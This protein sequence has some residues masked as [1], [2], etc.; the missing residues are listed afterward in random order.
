MPVPHIARPDPSEYVPYFGRYVE[1]VPD[2]DILALLERQIGETAALLAGLTEEQANA[3]Y[4]VG[5]WSIKEVIGHVAD[6]ERIFVYR[7]LRF[8][9][10]DHTPLPGF[11]QDDFVA[12]GNAHRQPLTALL[13]ELESV[14]AATLTFFRSLDAD[15]L[16]RRGTAENNAISVRAIPF[17]LAGHER[18]HVTVIEDRYLQ[19]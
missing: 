7:A 4:A 18:H 14:R 19:G 16:L 10:D 2:G 13:T 12:G 1:L 17:I 8:S 15:M 11:E 9:R 5:K 6:T 3:R